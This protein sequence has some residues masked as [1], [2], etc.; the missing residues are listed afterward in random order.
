MGMRYYCENEM[1][2]QIS[3]MMFFRFINTSFIKEKLGKAFIDSVEH[4]VRAHI[5]PH[6]KHYCFYLR[7]NLRHFDEFTNSVHEG[8]NN[9]IR[10][11]AAAVGP[12]TLI[13]KSLVIL[14]ENGYR[15]INNKIMETAKNYHS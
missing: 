14:S 9:G 10:H 5:E 8:T 7:K 2:Y 3:K 11:S 4:F 13:E 15:N 12:S 6:E 1:E